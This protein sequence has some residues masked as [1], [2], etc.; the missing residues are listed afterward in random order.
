MP[1]HPT[2]WSLQENTSGLVRQYLPKRTDLS[3]YTQQQLNE[4]AASLK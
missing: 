3:C 4:I 1:G 2:T